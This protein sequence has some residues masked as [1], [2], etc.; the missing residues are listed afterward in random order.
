MRNHSQ[1]LDAWLLR[2]VGLCF[3]AK[4]SQE[5]ATITGC[6]EDRQSQMP[7]VLF[8]GCFTAQ[9]NNKIFSSQ[10]IKHHFMKMI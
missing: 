9:S 2:W 1:S 6:I 3:F 4:I 8:I 5:K 10:D 7:M